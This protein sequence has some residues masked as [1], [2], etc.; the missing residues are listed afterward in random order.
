MR[1]FLVAV[2]LLGSL[3]VCGQRTDRQS[4]PLPPG[5]PKTQTLDAEAFFRSIVGEYDIPEAGPVGG[6]LQTFQY[7]VGTVEIFD[8]EV[9]LTFPYCPPG[10][11]CLPGYA[12]FLLKDV[13]VTTDGTT[14][15]FVATLDDGTV[16]R[17]HWTDAEGTLVF[18]NEQL[19][20]SDGSHKPI[21][22]HLRRR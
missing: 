7:Y 18:V 6:P 16:G 22:Y 19:E 15:T 14:A 1:T 11:G 21:E 20:H 4:T 2:A 9:G 8:Q 17:F 10:E 12:Y 5:T 13:V 3:S